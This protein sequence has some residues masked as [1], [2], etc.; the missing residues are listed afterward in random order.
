MAKILI[1]EDEEIIHKPIQSKLESEG[2]EVVLAR[3]GKEGLDKAFSDH[4]DLILLDIML[5]I[6]D[7]VTFL[8]ELR[9]DSWGKKVPVIVLSNLTNAMTAEESKAKGVR[10]YLVK[11]DW[12]LGDVV[13]KV[14]EEL[15]AD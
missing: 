4:P 3:D 2:F 12:K 8:E 9:K 6:M 1:I 15:E 10:A 14:K 7:G 11:T 5:P 13:K